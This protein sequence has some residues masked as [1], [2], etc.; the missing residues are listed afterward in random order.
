MLVLDRRSPDASGNGNLHLA[1]LL[2]L[3]RPGT[4]QQQR[5]TNRSRLRLADARIAQL[6]SRRRFVAGAQP[7]PARRPEHGK[8]TS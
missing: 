3:C 6:A 1:A 7:V 8:K 2:M 5:A 4:R